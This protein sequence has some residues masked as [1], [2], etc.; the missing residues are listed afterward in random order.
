MR[1][2]ICLFDIFLHCIRIGADF[3]I[4]PVSGVDNFV[5]SPHTCPGLFETVPG[6][7]RLRLD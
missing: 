2:T 6:S 4:H 5:S 3:A 1:P 7:V